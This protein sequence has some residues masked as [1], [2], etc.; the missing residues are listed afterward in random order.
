LNR[1]DAPT[2]QVLNRS[3]SEGAWGFMEFFRSGDEKPIRACF[4]LE[5]CTQADSQGEQEFVYAKIMLIN[6]TQVKNRV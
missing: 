4:W 1:R 6:G 3:F 5:Y 2:L